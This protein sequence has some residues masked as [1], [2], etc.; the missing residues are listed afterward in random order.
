[1]AEVSSSGNSSSS[2]S[3]L[4][5]MIALFTGLAIL[6]GVGLLVA[7]RVL[8]SAGLSAGTTR[9]TVRT[10]AGTYRLERENEV[11]P[12]LPV[13][14]RSSLVVPGEADAA[15]AIKAAKNGIETSTYH[16][17]DL[18]EF[19]DT[20]YTGHL[21]PDYTRHEPGDRT[22]SDLLRDSA[23]S[24]Q[25]ITF[26]ANRDQKVRVVALTQDSGGTRI[27]LIRLDLSAPSA[28]AAPGTVQPAT[29]QES[30][31]Q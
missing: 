29:P 20:W 30:A 25:D 11:G 9:N 19:V 4:W 12:A 3:L 14:P 16:T 22:A 18:R 31:P 17:T 15:D 7:S 2:K 27:S 5:M 23:V 28:Y 26:V 8:H 13:Y 21:S 1:M 24:N 6:L 10:A